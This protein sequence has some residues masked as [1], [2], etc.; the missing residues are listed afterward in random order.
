M[1]I[2]EVQKRNRR[3]DIT[4]FHG[5]IKKRDE[6][7]ANQLICVSELGFPQSIINEVKNRY[8]NTVVLM[9]LQEFDYIANPQRINMVNFFIVPHKQITIAKSE[10]IELSIGKDEAL[11][12][13]DEAAMRS[14]LEP[15]DF[16]R[17]MF[18][19]LN[20]PDKRS[21]SEIIESSLDSHP[22]FAAV[23]LTSSQVTVP[24]KIDEESN[25][26]IDIGVKRFR[27]KRWAFELDIRI[28]REARPNNVTQYVYRQEIANDAL[29]WVSAFELT[30][31]GQTTK[32]ELW[33]KSEAGALVFQLLQMGETAA[34]S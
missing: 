30:L 21:L 24:I 12:Q 26:F 13:E 15:L 28:E 11:H 7:G 6:V 8:G 10:P 17:K 9:T 2:V 29:A 20:Y 16:H 31:D 33:V 14:Y 34:I 5:W 25:V 22:Q 1:A 32:Y 4:T 3:P 23:E 19:F 18:S 27:I